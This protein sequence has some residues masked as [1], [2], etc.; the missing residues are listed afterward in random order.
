MVRR[1]QIRRRKDEQEDD[2]RTPTVFGKEVQPEE[3]PEAPPEPE[4]KKKLDEDDEMARMRS[5]I[6]TL[7]IA[8]EE[9]KKVRKRTPRK[10]VFIGPELRGVGNRNKAVETSGQDI[11][12]RDAK[13][14]E[15]GFLVAPAEREDDAPLLNFD[16]IDTTGIEDDDFDPE[17]VRNAIRRRRAV[18]Q[19]SDGDYFDA[20]LEGDPPPDL[21]LPVKLTADGLLNI[22][23][24]LLDQHYTLSINR[25]GNRY[26][27]D[28]DMRDLP[29]EEY[30]MTHQEML[31]LTE[32]EQ[33]REFSR[34][35]NEMTY[36]ERV[37][38]ANEN[39]VEWDEPQGSGARMANARLTR[40]VVTKLNIHHFKPQ[41][42][43]PQV[44]E[45]LWKEGIEAE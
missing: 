32:S 13:P 25:I 18:Q 5:I 31:D 45:R 6:D 4:P 33:W 36:E 7:P 39:G 30:A 22:V 38:Y 8:K 23:I 24:A 40:N 37:Q 29:P 44:R 42:A 14:E 21:G 34:L 15:K 19:E 11:S 26:I 20:T 9:P 41:Y 17:T 10:K 27:L 16:A 2:E 28:A 12:R 3:L 35:W 1:Q 43:N